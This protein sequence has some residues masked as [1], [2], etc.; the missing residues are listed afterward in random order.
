MSKVTKR[1]YFSANNGYITNSKLKDWVKD[2]NYFYRKHVLGTVNMEVTDAL[3]TGSAVDKWLTEN[4]QAF[5]EEYIIMARRDKK[6]SNYRLQLNQSMLDEVEGICRKVENQDAFR[7]MRGHKSQKILQWIFTEA[8]KHF[9]GIAGIPDWY[10]VVGDKAVITDLKT[11]KDGSLKAYK[12]ACYDYGYYQ[13]QAM[14][15]LLIEYNFPEVTD[16]ESRHLVVEKDK[17]GINKVYTY[18]LDQDL[19]DEAK[20]D[21]VDMLKEINEEEHFAPQNTNWDEARVI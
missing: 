10:K 18:I 3:I 19:I 14:Y 17:E 15:Q 8:G 11:T 20:D 16:F 21:I 9:I 13:Q 6:A 1:N 4:E 12:Y 5:R 2:K 7:K